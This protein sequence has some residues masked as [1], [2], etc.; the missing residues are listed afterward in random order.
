[1]EQHGTEAQLHFDLDLPGSSRE[2]MAGYVRLD[3]TK[4]AMDIV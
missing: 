2:A 3:D 1:M 4:H